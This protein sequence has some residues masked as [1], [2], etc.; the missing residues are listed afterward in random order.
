[1]TTSLPFCREGKSVNEKSHGQE[2]LSEPKH[3]KQEVL[4]APAPQLSMVQECLA[5][6]H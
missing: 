5:Q 3:Y 4:L 1:M 6:A 2:F